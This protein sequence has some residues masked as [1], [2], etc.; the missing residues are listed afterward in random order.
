LTNNLKNLGRVPCT[1]LEQRWSE[2]QKRVS[3][4]AIQVGRRPDEITVLAVSKYASALDVCF[5]HQQLGIRLFGENRLERYEERKRLGIYSDC[6]WHMIGHVQSKKAR[7]VTG[8]FSLI[9]SVDTTK[10]ARAISRAGMERGIRQR[11]LLQVNMSDEEAKHGFTTCAT[12]EKRD[13]ILEAMPELAVLP[14]IQID[15]LMT[16]APFA[17]ER[18]VIRLVFQ[19]LRVLRDRLQHDYPNLSL[20]HLSMGMS[21]DFDVAIAEGATIVRLGSILFG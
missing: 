19:Q 7:N 14:G 9:H 18:D 3:N 5:A 20:C 10:L 6:E 8:Q 12:A 1:E 15:G 21:D 17:A 2:I 16:M 4:A 13:N 11:I